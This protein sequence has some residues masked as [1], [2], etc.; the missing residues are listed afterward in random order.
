MEKES[1]ASLPSRELRQIY[2][3]C[4][5]A[6][7]ADCLWHRNQSSLA[8]QNCSLLIS[9]RNPGIRNEE[10]WLPVWQQDP[11]RPQDTRT[12]TTHLHGIWAL[13]DERDLQGNRQGEVPGQRN[14]LSQ[15]FLHCVPEKEKK[16]KQGIWERCYKKWLLEKINFRAFN[17]LEDKNYHRLKFFC[18]GKSQR[19][20]KRWT[21]NIYM[22]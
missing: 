10:G 21:I 19:E 15:H 5:D 1:P 11:G 13:Q 20:T 22:S 17:L 9:E 7:T 3:T 18:G 2:T 12:K 4:S 8:A 14:C 6:R 16:K